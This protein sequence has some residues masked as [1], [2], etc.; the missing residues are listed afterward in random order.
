M[1]ALAGTLV[2]ACSQG[3]GSHSD[4]TQAALVQVP[5]F[6]L[7]DQNSISATFTKTI[8]PRDYLGMAPGFYF[9]HAD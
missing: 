9:T 7:L 2:P 6:Q 3:S 5:N 4:P 1:L 8:S